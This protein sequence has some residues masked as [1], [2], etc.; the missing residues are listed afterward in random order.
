[1][2]EKLKDAG[3][4]VDVVRKDGHG[5]GGS[6]ESAADFSLLIFWGCLGMLLLAVCEFHFVEIRCG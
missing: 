2:V 3:A 1:M 4:K 5:L 6:L